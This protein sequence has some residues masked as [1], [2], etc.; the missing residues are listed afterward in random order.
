MKKYYEAN[1]SKATKRIKRMNGY[2]AQ[3]TKAIQ[4]NYKGI[5]DGKD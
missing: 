4:T 5:A 2:K 1:R 3:N